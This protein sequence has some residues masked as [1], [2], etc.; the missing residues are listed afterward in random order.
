MGEAGERGAVREGC[1]QVVD[2]GS[3]EFEGLPYLEIEPA[4]Q[5]FAVLKDPSV[6][7]KRY[8]SHLFGRPVWLEFGTWADRCGPD[9][10]KISSA[11]PACPVIEIGFLEDSDCGTGYFHV[12]KHSCITDDD[13]L[14]GHS[15]EYKIKALLDCLQN[16]LEYGYVDY[17]EDRSGPM[18][19]LDHADGWFDRWR[20]D[21]ESSWDKIEASAPERT[22]VIS[23]KNVPA[24]I[25]VVPI[26]LLLLPVLILLSLYAMIRR[27]FVQSFSRIHR[28]PP[29]PLD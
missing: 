8:R 4:E 9:W 22:R 13:V 10:V 20:Q 2:G 25:V 15:D 7:G 16:T 26:M 29:F 12:G 23:R 19:S 17:T 1:D 18:R 21:L 11:N 14:Y 3:D 6:H 5:L 24:L 28:Y 27:T